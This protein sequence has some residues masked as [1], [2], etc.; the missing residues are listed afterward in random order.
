MKSRIL[1]DLHTHTTYSHG[2]GSILD[3]VK[4]AHELGLQKIGIADHG[5]GHHTYGIKLSD[6]EKMREDIK[7]ANEMYPDVEVLLGVEANIC[8]KDGSLDVSKDEQKLFDFVIAGYHYACFGKNKFFGTKL[9]VGSWLSE[10]KWPI[11]IYQIERNT[12]MIVKAL[13]E[14]DILTLTHPGDKM[15]VDIKRIAQAAEKTN[16]L[17]E[18]NNLHGHM[19]LDEIVTASFYDVKFILGSDAH[20]P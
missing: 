19:N 5:P 1:Y 11:S 13:Y 6:V 4:A 17:L 3:N 8:N 20:Q 14:N 16:T 15:R 7:L 10:H 9:C 18:I 12:D 2:L